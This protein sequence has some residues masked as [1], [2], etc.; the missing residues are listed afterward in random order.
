MAEGANECEW[1]SLQ[2]VLFPSTR[3]VSHCSFIWQ[4]G[5]AVAVV[6]FV[7]CERLCRYISF[8]ICTQGK[9]KKARTD[10]RY[11]QP[12]QQ[13][14]QQQNNTS[15]RNGITTYKQRN[16]YS[17]ELLVFL[18]QP[19]LAVFYINLFIMREWNQSIYMHKYI[20]GSKCNWSRASPTDQQQEREWERGATKAKW[21]S[22]V[23]M[24]VYCVWLSLALPLCIARLLLCFAWAIRIKMCALV[25]SPLST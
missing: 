6:V 2:V 20:S 16:Y 12:R 15:T 22:I 23:G 24:H 21:A 17:C 25:R 8:W 1:C 14:Q 4:F 3:F 5:V 18:C 9:K 13:E 10:S 19:L 7:A 11:E